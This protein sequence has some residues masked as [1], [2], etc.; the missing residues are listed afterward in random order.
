MADNQAQGQNGSV[1]ISYSRKDKEFV[2]KLYDGLVANDVKAWVDWEGIPLSADWMEEISHAVNGA[3]A[4]LVVISPDWLASKVCADELE[5]GLKSNKKLIPILH[6]DPLSGTTLPGKLAATNWVYLREQ[7]DFDGTLPKLIEAINTDLDWVRQHTRLLE[8]AIEWDRKKRNSSFLLQGTDLEEGEKWMSM[9][10]QNT[11][12]EV[13][14]LQ[15]EYV[16]TSRKEAIRRQRRLLIGVS[17]GL[18]VSILLGIFALAQ[19]NAAVTNET[20]ANHNAATAVANEN[21]RA[22][23]QSIAQENEKLAKQNEAL[24]KKNET[25]AIRNETLAR[26]QRNAAEAKLYQAKAG[27]LDVSTLLAIESWQSSPSFQA[28][29][30]LRQNISLLPVPV[31]QMSQAGRIYDIQF[32][33]DEKWFVT[34]S[35]D[36]T[37]CVW[38]LKS[39]QKQYCVQHEKS[40]YQAAFSSDGNWLATASEDGSTRLWNASDGSLDRQFDLGGTAWDVKFSPNSQ[41]LVIGHE[42]GMKAVSLV[43]SRQKELNV[44]T[45]GAAYVLAYSPDNNWVAIGT[46][47]GKLQIWRTGSL[48]T[49]SVPAHSDEVLAITFSP[50]GKSI[51]SSSADSTARVTRTE[52]G[53]EIWV[54]RSGDW[55]EDIESS[56]DSTWSVAA[57]DDNR[58]WVWDMKT[59]E[60]KMRLSHAGFVQKVEVSPDGQWIASTGFDQT[61]RVWDARSGSQMFQAALTGIGS[62][63]AFSPDGQHLIAGDRD[64]NINVWDISALS[65]R[66]GSLEFAEYVHEV[67]LS[68]DGKSMLANSDDRKVWSFE[69][70]KTLSTHTTEAAT[71]LFSANGLTYNLNISPDSNWVVAAESQN[72]KAVLYNSKQGQTTIL[73]HNSYVTGAAFTPDNLQVATSGKDGKVILWNVQ[74]GEKRAEL[75]NPATVLGIAISP[76]GSKLVAGLDGRASTTVWDLTT[77]IKI[78]ELDQVGNVNAVTF[79]QDGK[80]VATGD[81]LGVINIWN[82]QDF[83]AGQPVRIL[84]L[85]SKVLDMLFSPDRHWLVVGSS[86]GYAQIFDMTSGDEISRIPHIGEVTG[87]AFSSDGKQLFTVSRK[88]VQVWDVSALTLTPT[89]KLID[90]ACSRL[91]ANLS[92][93]EWQTLFYKEPYHLICPSLPQGRD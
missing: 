88:V 21:A 11:K 31:G 84:Q 35:E 24:A 12:R 49:N 87:L 64:G 56:P 79:S 33:P 40:V 80:W 4:F 63:L 67:K 69:L 5:L 47:S 68:P 82:A 9:A 43:D 91:A 70:S 16:S 42:N 59:G 77:R 90:T 15:A 74:T 62:G 6:R 14:P 76:D 60:S 38:N 2:R 83:T 28:E 10:A 50:D 52:S 17:L 19:R 20:R 61:V 57:S 75:V 55:V 18:V 36:G 41:W 89:S 13:L 22:T 45:F 34:P 1:F 58:V 48:Y 23:Q 25:L 92:L 78:G 85:N 30:I 86:D 29:E 3:D 81:N 54:F 39:S 53:K 46:G 26:A 65:A 8:R 32:S 72:N 73:D 27:K 7:D 71:V 93:T 66:I 51:L 37:A 44:K